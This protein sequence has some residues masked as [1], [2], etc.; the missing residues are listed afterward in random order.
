MHEWMNESL[1]KMRRTD[2]DY[3]IGEKN[4]FKNGLCLFISQKHGI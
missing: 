1:K 4:E 3:I 2:I